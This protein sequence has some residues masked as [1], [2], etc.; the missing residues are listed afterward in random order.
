MK[1]GFCL[2]YVILRPPIPWAWDEDSV[3]WVFWFHLKPITMS[4]LK[5]LSLQLSSRIPRAAGDQVGRAVKNAPYQLI[6]GQVVI[7]FH[8]S[9][10][11]LPLLQT[12][13]NGKNSQI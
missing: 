10:I 13:P 9:S 7:S 3:K 2:E 8:L 1:L 5:L 12:V 11:T 6:P 4:G